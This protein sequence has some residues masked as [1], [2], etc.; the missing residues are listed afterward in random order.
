LSLNLAP[1]GNDGEGKD[2]V[3]G[4]GRGKLSTCDK[5]I[6]KLAKQV[7]DN[8]PRGSGKGS[9]EQV[10]A[11]IDVAMMAMLYT[12][13]QRL[14]GNTNLIITTDGDDGAADDDGIADHDEGTRVKDAAG[15]VPKIM[16]KTLLG[17]TLFIPWAA[18]ATVDALKLEI[19]LTESIPPEQQLLYVNGKRLEDGMPLAAY[20]IVPGTTVRVA[21]RL[22]GGVVKRARTAGPGENPFAAVEEK[23]IAP[24]DAPM[25]A[26]TLD[27]VLQYANGDFF[28]TLQDVQPAV[29]VQM[30]KFVDTGKHKT[31]CR[32]RGLVDI[33][34]AMVSLDELKSKLDGT[35][36]RVHRKFGKQI[37]DQVVEHTEKKDFS[38]DVLRVMIRNIMTERDVVM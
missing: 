14:K 29:L 2:K 25:I 20:G 31:D 30:K 15:Y 17:S 27:T 10:G 13:V 23:F 33:L 24:G 37:W 32:I 28:T 11:A 4:T 8:E 5:D 3:K 6:L 26:E 9:Q 38:I 22:F 34:P 18:D 7:A 21:A 35:R 1:K 16:I 19:E 12:I 36:E